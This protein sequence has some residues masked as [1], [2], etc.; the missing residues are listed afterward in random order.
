MRE[1]LIETARETI[2]N[3]A[4]VGEWVHKTDSGMLEVD[5]TIDLEKV[6]DAIL[7][8]LRQ[9]DEVM[10]RAAEDVDFLAPGEPNSAGEFA[11]M[12]DAARAGK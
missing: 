10:L 8:E 3:D 6:V 12:I 9:P 7:A 1:R 4:V 5:G 2:M 11:A